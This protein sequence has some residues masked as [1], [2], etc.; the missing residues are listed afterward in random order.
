MIC[1]VLTEIRVKKK[2]KG[3]KKG[4]KRNKES[5][6]NTVWRKKNESSSHNPDI[7][8]N[9]STTPP[10]TGTPAPT[11]QPLTSPPHTTLIMVAQRILHSGTLKHSPTLNKAVDATNLTLSPSSSSTSSK[12]ERRNHTLP[13]SPYNYHTTQQPRTTP[14]NTLSN[15][16]YSRFLTP[17]MLSP[18][19]P[20]KHFQCPPVSSGPAKYGHTLPATVPITVPHSNISPY[21]ALSMQKQRCHRDQQ[22]TTGKEQEHFERQL[23][24]FN[25]AQEQ[26]IVGQTEDRN[27]MG[28]KEHDDDEEMFVLEL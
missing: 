23:L 11:P 14:H 25:Q 16:Y 24:L 22:E 27:T 3:Q 17:P 13:S 9:F 4:G 1:V 20:T 21:R 12:N 6:S 7:F 28:E 2:L 19:T 10:C 8:A 18:R 15:E 26:S 5:L